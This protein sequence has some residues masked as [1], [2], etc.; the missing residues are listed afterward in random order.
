[1][2]GD[3]LACRGNQNA[4]THRSYALTAKRDAEDPVAM[5]S[6]AL[7]QRGETI[8][9]SNPVIPSGKLGYFLTVEQDSQLRSQPC[10]HG[11]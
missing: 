8:H 6:N 7:V 2:L 3:I 10:L 4:V 1:M 5:E 9:K 11:L